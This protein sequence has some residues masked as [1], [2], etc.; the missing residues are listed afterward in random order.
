M[1]NQQVILQSD[2]AL[3]A[4]TARSRAARCARNPTLG[5]LLRVARA[6]DTDIATLTSALREDR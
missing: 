5:A 2:G 3:Q 1:A 6:L 4:P